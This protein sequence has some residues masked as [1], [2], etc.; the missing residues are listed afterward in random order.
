MGKILVLNVYHSFEWTHHARSGSPLDDY[1]HLTSIILTCTC[2]IMLLVYLWWQAKQAD[3]MKKLGLPD[4]CKLPGF[5]LSVK[6]TE[7]DI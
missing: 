4:N 6:W 1:Q 2:M 3:A 5:A 7:L